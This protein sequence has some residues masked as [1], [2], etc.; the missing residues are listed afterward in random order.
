MGHFILQRECFCQKEKNG[1]IIQ[2]NDYQ[3]VERCLKTKNDE[4]VAWMVDTV[5]SRLKGVL[6]IIWKGQVNS[7]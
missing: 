2:A 6:Q 1:N 3:M 5:C 7:C 4:G